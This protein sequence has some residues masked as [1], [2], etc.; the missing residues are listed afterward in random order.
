MS[1]RRW[2]ERQGKGGK[3]NQFLDHCVPLVCTAPSPTTTPPVSIPSFFSR[4]SL[5]PTCMPGTVLD[6]RLTLTWFHSITLF[7][8]PGPPF[9]PSLS[10]VRPQTCTSTRPAHVPTRMP[11]HTPTHPCTHSPAHTLLPIRAVMPPPT[12]SR[13]PNRTAS[14][15]AEGRA[16]RY[17]H[18]PHGHAPP[19]HGHAL[20]RPRQPVT[21]TSPTH[22]QPITNTSP[23]HFQ[24]SPTHLL[25]N[26][27][28][29][30]THPLPTHYQ[31]ITD[32]LPTH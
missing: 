16:V 26:P 31:P 18:A 1:K 29:T 9:L 7:A 30:I 28:P 2:E 10:Y 4:R 25:T 17:G 6:N 23:T 5:G 11:M 15:S 24:P 21:N 27:L 32:T 3:D 19:G 12:R 8:P 20:P 22:Y 14:A 13:S